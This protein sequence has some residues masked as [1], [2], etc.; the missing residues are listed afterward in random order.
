MREVGIFT[1]SGGRQDIEKLGA[2]QKGHRTAVMA[3]LKKGS[4]LRYHAG[5]SRA[6]ASYNFGIGRPH[7]NERKQPERR[8]RRARDSEV[9]PLTLRLVG[10]TPDDKK[11]WSV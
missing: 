1:L 2:L 5:R 9:G 11:S 4:R 3:S 7:R 6:K 10:A 8:P